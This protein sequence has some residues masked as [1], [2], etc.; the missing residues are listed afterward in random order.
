MGDVLQ[1]PA[2][3]T[4]SGVVSQFP[5]TNSPEQAWWYVCVVLCTL[6]PGVLLIIRLYT[7]LYIIRKA[8]VADCMLSL[9]PLY[10]SCVLTST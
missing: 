5:T 2:L 8:D 10:V 1:Q 6:I 4:P 3:A 9:S 7:K